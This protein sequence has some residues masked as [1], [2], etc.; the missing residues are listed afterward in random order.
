MGSRPP[1]DDCTSFLIQQ[2]PRTES[3]CLRWRG[4]TRRKLWRRASARSLSRAVRDWVTARTASLGTVSEVLPATSDEGVWFWAA[5]R[6]LELS[7]AL[8]YSVV[9]ALGLV[10]NSLALHLLHSC[11][12]QKHQLLRHGPCSHRP[13]VRSHAALLGRGYGAGLPLPAWQSHAQNRQLRHHHEHVRQ[14]LLPAGHERGSVLF[15]HLV[16]EDAQPEGGSGWDLG[17]WTVSP[18][19]MLPHAVY[20]TVAQVATDKELC[21]VRF[22]ESGSWDP[23]F[24]LGLYRLRKFLLGFVVPLAV[25]TVRYLLLLRFVLSRKAQGAMVREREQGRHRPR[26]EV[27]KSLAIMVLSFFLCWLPN[28]TLTTWAVL[29]KFDLAPFSNLVQHPGLRL[30]PQC[31][32]GPGRQLPQPSALPADLPA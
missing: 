32:L 24:L 26:C 14:R 16:A 21:L 3:A 28:Q 31:L 22:P 4:T 19:A 11:Y 25:I 7:S 12:R 17:I 29:T 23:Q 2:C 27:T 20:S 13:A 30:P 15:R 8:V 1:R 18:I 5:R 6:Q 9:C 10:G